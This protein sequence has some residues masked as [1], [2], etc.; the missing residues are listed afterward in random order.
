MVN[1]SKGAIPPEWMH[2]EKKLSGKE[3]T[4]LCFNFMAVNA[5]DCRLICRN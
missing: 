5:T 4:H 1:M 2:V 3:D